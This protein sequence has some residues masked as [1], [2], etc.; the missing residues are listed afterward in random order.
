[1]EQG[2]TTGMYKHII[3]DWSIIGFR[4]FRRVRRGSCHYDGLFIARKATLYKL[5]LLEVFTVFGLLFL[6]FA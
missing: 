5:A 6:R 4:F 2:T 3:I 1:M